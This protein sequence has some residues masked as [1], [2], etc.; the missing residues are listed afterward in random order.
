MPSFTAS[1]GV[2][3][4][5][6]FGIQ[7][8][9]ARV[10]GKRRTVRSRGG[11][12][13]G[14]SSTVN[15]RGFSPFVRG[16]PHVAT[17]AHG[18]D[19]VP[20][21]SAGKG[22]GITRAHQVAERADPLRA[23]CGR[24]VYREHWRSVAAGP[25]RSN[26]IRPYAR[27]RLM[28]DKE[29]QQNVR[30]ALD[31]DPSVDVAEVGITVE[32]GIVTLRGD[33]MSYSE[34]FNAE[35]AALRVYGVK[36]VAND[37]D[38]T[39]PGVTARTDTDIAAAAVNSFKW[40]SQVPADRVSVVVSRG[41]ITLKG[42]VDWYYQ[43]DA[44]ERSVRHLL[45][46]VGVTNSISVRPHVNVADVKTKIEA[47]LKRSAEVDARRINVSASDGQVVLSGNVHS[48]AERREAIQ[49][50]WAAPGVR[51]VDDRMAIVP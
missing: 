10:W 33:V 15:R 8:T 44:A 30:N 13:A 28:T 18:Q 48:W 46:V 49:A 19:A 17:Q 4:I 51:S 34:K 42:E 43:R 39:I 25:T 7:I 41:W 2:V 21:D 14:R 32:N 12:A 45:G 23:D 24:Y 37:L 3:D 35:R 1:L 20:L 9:N 6:L 31:W 22:L 16:I 29:L 26:V 11:T 27:R 47:A 40:N 50:A 36:A 38:V 5:V